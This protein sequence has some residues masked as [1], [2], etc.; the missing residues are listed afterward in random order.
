MN[1]ITDANFVKTKKIKNIISESA[2]LA[3]RDYLDRL[4][5]DAEEKIE[6]FSRNIVAN[7]SLQSK[8]SFNSSL[9]AAES[10]KEKLSTFLNDIEK[11]SD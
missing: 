5:Q 1:L 8:A 9:E 10:T 2:K 3:I 7:I 11:S 4:S 6:K